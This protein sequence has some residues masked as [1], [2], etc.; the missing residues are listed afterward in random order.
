METPRELKRGEPSAEADTSTASALPRARLASRPSFPQPSIQLALFPTMSSSSMPSP[1][2]KVRLVLPSRTLLL[3]GSG[4]LGFA[5]RPSEPRPSERRASE[6]A[7]SRVTLLAEPSPSCSGD[8]K[9]SAQRSDGPDIC[10]LRPD[11]R[12][13]SLGLHRYLGCVLSAHT[14]YLNSAGSA[15]SR[16][17]PACSCR[18]AR[19]FSTRAS[20]SSVPSARRPRC[21]RTLGKALPS[22]PLR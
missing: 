11:P 6:V 10:P 22:D 13:R 9:P 3:S 4:D 19:P 21:A 16:L 8:P 5:I 1:G 12:H 17:Y 15:D 14:P 2:C 20:R 18:R 7:A